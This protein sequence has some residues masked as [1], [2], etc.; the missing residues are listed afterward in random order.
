MEDVR[1]KQAQ[2][3]I[4]KSTERKTNQTVLKEPKAGNIDVK[5]FENIYRNIIKAED[6]IYSSLPTHNLDEKTAKE[7]T[8]CLL[9]ARGNI[10]SILSGFGVL[11]EQED[12]VDL[13]ELS[14]SI[15]FITPKNNYKKTLKKLG[16]NTANIIIAEVPLKIEDM[17][18]I[19]PK[20]PDGALKGISKKIEHI[21]NDIERK[22]SSINPEKIIVVGEKDINGQL[23]GKRAEEKYNSTSFLKDN[24][25]DL[26]EEELLNLIQ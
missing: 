2:N 26:T 10:D 15:L 12:D 20:I 24:F 3:L 17:K 4:I 16:I 19:N 23:L 18:E 6:F 9:E 22:I 11:E 5:N 8:K 7:F 21:H 14:A 1:L 13:S 25:K